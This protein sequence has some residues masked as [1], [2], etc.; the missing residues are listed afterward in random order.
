MDTWKRSL[1]QWL[2]FLLTN[3]QIG[4]LA[5]GKL[6]R[7]PWKQFCNPGLN[8][9]SCPAAV[10]ACPIGAMQAVA[11]SVQYGFSFLVTGSLLLAGIVLGRGVCGYLCPFGLIQEL[12]HKIPLPKRKL[13][14]KFLLYLKYVLLVLFVLLIPAW[15]TNYAG[16]GEPAFCKYICPAGTLEGGIPLL[17][18]HPELRQAMGALFAW[19]MGIL[20]LTIA[21]CIVISR[22]FCKV[23][24]PLGALYSL[25]NKYSLFHLDI[26]PEKCVSCGHCKTIC[27]MD[28]NP[29]E[30]PDSGECIRCGSCAKSCP[31]QAIRLKWGK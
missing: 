19:K 7:G 29:V 18:M 11:G 1:I 20:I 30:A 31:Q 10:T 17:L 12:L 23:L 8:C 16:I 6:Y 5:A 13:P 26:N 28:V 14:W 9:Y 25:L 4:N 2:A 24:C 3:S 15:M 21:G 22:F 27:P